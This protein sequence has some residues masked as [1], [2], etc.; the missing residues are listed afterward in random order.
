MSGPNSLVAPAAD[1]SPRVTPIADLSYRNYDGPLRSRSV[2]WWIVSLATMRANVNRS[3]LGFWMPAALILLTYLIRAV[4]FYFTQGV[5]AQVEAQ[6]VMMPSGPV[7]PYA[8]ALYQSMALPFVSLMVFI[9]AL[10]IGSASIAADNRAN[11]LLVYLSKPLTRF[12]YLL[13]K[14]MGIFLLLASLIVVPSL[15]TYL[16]FVGAYYS[17]GFLKDNPT[18]I[19][20]LLLAGMLP[21]ALHA[22]LIIG[23]SA[24]SKSARIA[25]SV[26]AAF[27]LMTGLLVLIVG[28]ALWWSDKPGKHILRTSIILH[29]SVDGVRNGLAQHL[30]DVEPP[31]FGG[32]NASGRRRHRA[33]P[34]RPDRAFPDK[35]PERP[36]LYALLLIGGAVVAIPLVAAA[37]KVRAVEVVRG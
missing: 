33:Q 23:F 16:F 20:R 28:N 26:Y 36:P 29:S 5:R 31:S 8:D 30:Y 14:W 35:A 22:S 12:D 11:A 24:W 3:R 32:W 15:L 4:V 6:G 13:G 2:R 34:N 18:L 37:V 25:G 9:A 21:A 19:L 7:N 27:Y 1:A 10:V 17:D